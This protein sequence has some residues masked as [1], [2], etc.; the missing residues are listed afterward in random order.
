MSNSQR[1]KSVDIGNGCNAEVV[2]EFIYL[3]DI[4]SVDGDADAAVTASICSC[5]FQF[6]SPASFLTGKDVFLLL[7]GK[8][9]DA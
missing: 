2:N 4:L 7:R 8:V 1:S 3:G 6:T 9:Y 5:W